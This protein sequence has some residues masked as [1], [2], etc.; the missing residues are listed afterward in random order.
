MKSWICADTHLSIGHTRVWCTR[1][2]S[3][4]RAQV[5]T[6]RKKRDVYDLRQDWSYDG[7]TSCADAKPL[8]RTRI[9]CHQQ[10]H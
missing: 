1:I 9:S 2:H 3:N 5:S 6:A 8:T 4:R 7:M 10:L